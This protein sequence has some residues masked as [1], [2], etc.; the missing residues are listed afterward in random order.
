MAQHLPQAIE[1]SVATIL[2][3]HEEF[4]GLGHKE[5]NETITALLEAEFGGFWKVRF[6]IV[7]FDDAVRTGSVVIRKSGIDYPFSVR[8]E[9]R[10]SAW[11]LVPKS[12]Q[13]RH[14]PREPV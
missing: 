2:H 1:E 10:S 11:M 13:H 12:H 3:T 6:V 4:A 9:K 14:T 8:L 7:C 5:T